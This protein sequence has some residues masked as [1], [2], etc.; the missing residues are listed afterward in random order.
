MAT[1]SNTVECR[2]LPG[3][4]GSLCQTASTSG[5]CSLV[6]CQNGGVC[7]VTSSNTAQCQCRTGFTG[8]V[9]QTPT[10]TTNP[11]TF[12]TC[13]NGKYKLIYRDSFNIFLLKWMHYKGGVCVVTSSNT[14]QCN[15]P[16][17]FTGLN[18]QTSNNFSPCSTFTC[19]NGTY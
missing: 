9:C 6:V 2:C 13:L 14:A 1:S 16:T 10:S 8:S 4:T 7:V 15:C 11:C 18:C 3:F 5:V 17:G 12:F 19:L